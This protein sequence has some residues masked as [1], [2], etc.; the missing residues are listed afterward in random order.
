MWNFCT[1]NHH[2]CIE[3][4][5]ILFPCYCHIHIYRCNV[6]IHIFVILRLRN[7]LFL[8]INLL[9]NDEVGDTTCST[10]IM[11]LHVWWMLN[12][13]RLVTCNAG[14]TIGAPVRSAASK[15]GWKDH[16]KIHQLWSQHMKGNTTI[17]VQQ[18]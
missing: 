18:R 14:A 16:S 5:S 11:I 1:K 9:S 10:M 2:M 13:T 6:M 4:Q 17:T 7:G 12:L 15:K 8:V 3:T